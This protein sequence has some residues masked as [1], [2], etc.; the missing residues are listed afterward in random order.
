M[1]IEEKEGPSQIY[2]QRI[3]AEAKVLK[4]E[5]EL[6]EAKALQ[7]KLTAKTSFLVSDIRKVGSHVLQTNSLTLKQAREAE[8]RAMTLAKEL[9]AAREHVLELNKKQYEG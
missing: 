8:G 2:S 7:L 4:L 9:Q 6:S 3:D 1:H 5:Q